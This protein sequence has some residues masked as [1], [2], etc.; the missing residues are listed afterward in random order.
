MGSGMVAVTS[1]SLALGGSARRNGSTCHHVRLMN[2]LY[3]HWDSVLRCCQGLS[4]WYVRSGMFMQ[5]LYSSVGSL[6]L[7]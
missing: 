4:C 2:A 6:S 3:M 1:S 5:A 7:V